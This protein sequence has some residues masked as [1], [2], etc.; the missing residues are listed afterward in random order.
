MRSQANAAAQWRQVE[1]LFDAAL[2][3]AE[4]ERATFLDQACAGDPEL[5]SEVESLLQASG[6]TGAFIARAVEGAVNFIEKTDAL[7]ADSR[8][9]PY[10]IVRE[11]GSGGMGT[12]YLA[13]RSDSEYR[14]QVAIKVVKRGMDTA[15][16]LHR[17]REERQILANLDHPNICRLLD[18][19]TT[20]DGRPYLVMDYVDGQPVTAFIREHKLSLEARLRLFESI[21]AAVDH[22]H[23]NLIIHRDIKPGNILVGSDGVPR[24]LD[25]GI[26][27]L[28]D[29]SHSG[30]TEAYTSG[31]RML[32]PDYASPEQVRGERLSTATDVYSLGAVLFEVLTGERP[33]HARPV[34][35]GE[36]ES[37]NSLSDILKPSTVARRTNSPDVRRIRGDL[38]NI[39]LMATRPEPDRRYHT[40][41]QLAEDIGR[42]L[43]GLPILAR[44]DPLY[45]AGKLVRRYRWAAL[46]VALIAASLVGGT[47]AAHRQAVRAE[48]EAA[49]ANHRFQQVRQLAGVFLFEFERRIRTL[50]GATDA[51]EFVAQT[52]AQY[53]DNLAAESSG[54]L[55]LQSELASAYEKLAEIR[56]SPNAASLGERKQAER[57][58]EKSVVLL[59]QVHDGKPDDLPTVSKLVT[60]LGTLCYLKSEQGEVPAALRR[61]TEAQTVARNFVARH[62][63]HAAVPALAYQHFRVLGMFIV[64][65]VTRERRWRFTRRC[66]P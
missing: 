37:S 50:A 46:A 31:L 17:F 6:H 39:V 42:Y 33:R 53:L 23:R 15:A 27:K 54:D 58:Y 61:C 25:F 8:L 64:G 57:L 41:E 19:G 26:A 60:T 18:G 48:H 11:L 7:A 59:R 63:E 21:C 1:S 9:G 5:R 62:A 66:V 4:G 30:D 29:G 16:I 43:R 14:K 3:L 35:L 47:I 2:D 28:T 65:R 24:L 52:A 20:P 56:G 32:T 40:A 44:R 51:R 38:D 34:G 45:R 55:D 36:P 12:V 49:K 10:R 13:E 22:A